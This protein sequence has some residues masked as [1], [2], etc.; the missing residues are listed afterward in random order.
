MSSI[1]CIYS[2]ISLPGGPGVV[3][4]PVH[5]KGGPLGQPRAADIQLQ[6]KKIYIDFKN[7]NCQAFYFHK[8]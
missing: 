3:Q 8:I 4:Q 5:A 7:S 1:A 6:E 2:E